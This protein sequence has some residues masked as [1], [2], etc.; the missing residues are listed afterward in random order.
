MISGLLQIIYEDSNL[1]RLEKEQANF[2]AMRLS[3][4]TGIAKNELELFL[5]LLLISHSEGS[6]VTCVRQC[7]EYLCAQGAQFDENTLESI[8][9][10]IAESKQ[11][12]VIHR[13]FNGQRW[14][15]FQ[16]AFAAEQSTAQWLKNAVQTKNCSHEKIPVKLPARITPHALQLQA[17]QMAMCHRFCII[18]GGPGT[19]KT[20]VV[21]AL[22]ENVCDK[23]QILPERVALC[24]P[25][26][27]AKA[28]LSESVGGQYA[29][30]T[31]H[32]LLAYQDNGEPR[33][34]ANRHLPY[35]LLVIDE[36]SMVDSAMFSHLINALAPSTRLVLV[37]DRNQLP[38]V[39]SGAVLGDL[40][41]GQYEFLQNIFVELTHNFRTCSRILQWWEMAQQGQVTS[42]EELRVSEENVQKHI[43]QWIQE[44]KENW[45]RF[46]TMNLD[47][48]NPHHIQE[49]KAHVEFGRI[50]TCTNY[51]LQGRERWNL[52]CGKMWA[53]GNGSRNYTHSDFLDGE[54]L[55]VEKN[56][57]VGAISLYNGDLGVAYLE[58][59]LMQGLFYSGGKL[60]LVPLDRV[61]NVQRA[62]AI[63]VHKAQGTEF[64]KV[65]LILPAE[66]NRVLTKPLVYTAITRA[67]KELIVHDSA[68]H[69]ARGLPLGVR[70]T[71]LGLGLDK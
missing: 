30:F 69:I 65:V 38:S 17:I 67:R 60:C 6:T 56:Q 47:L 64:S 58:N 70:Y 20:T 15:G 71:W 10:K 34:T 61:Q 26:G 19:G 55:I 28:R 53:Q 57:Q 54:L 21:C 16:R 59:G 22:I 68:N 3:S 32:A 44:Q 12:L 2:L 41:Q 50:L 40:T 62:Y 39:E 49:F 25:T 63:T 43:A 52:E 45:R 51:G 1:G 31:V 11:T 5:L 8:F 29:S 13:T 42:G 33:Y 7:A 9:E 4:H 66:A 23:H 46:R 36:V 18:S 27:R 35:D 48:Q 14:W 37:G 24:A